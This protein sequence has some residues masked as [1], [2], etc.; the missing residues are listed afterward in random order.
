MKP[1]FYRSQAIPMPLMHVFARRI[2]S[3]MLGLFFLLTALVL[4]SPLLAHAAKADPNCTLATPCGLAKYGG[5]ARV[6]DQP[7]AGHKQ[8]FKSIYIIGKTADGKYNVYNITGPLDDISYEV[9]NIQY[10]GGDLIRLLP[11]V[12]KA[13]VGKTVQCE[14]ICKNAAGQVVGVNPAYKNIA[15]GKKK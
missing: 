13:D 3:A 5:A 8:V 15:V 1:S 7:T 2:G 4:L 14:T 12:D 10:S 6:V 9:N 11:A